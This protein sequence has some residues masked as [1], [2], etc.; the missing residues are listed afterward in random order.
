MLER[1]CETCGTAFLADVADCPSA[2]VRARADVRQETHTGGGSAT[3][4][5]T[6]A[7]WRRRRVPPARYAR[8]AAPCLRRASEPRCT[9]QTN[10]GS[11]LMPGVSAQICNGRQPTLCLKRCQISVPRMDERHC[12]KCGKAFLP[13]QGSGGRPQRFC[14]R[15]CHVRA[16]NS[17]RQMQ[18]A[19]KSRARRE[20]ASIVA[21]AWAALAPSPGNDYC[22]TCPGCGAVFAP[23]RSDVRYCSSECRLRAYDER[24][25]ANPQAGPDPRSLPR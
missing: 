14:S 20:A 4:N 23:S 11:A 19:A 24:R 5:G 16:S 6:P 25:R 7:G 21:Q 18:A 22:T 12:K 8:S 2:S 17:R 10:A 3:P 1:H 9:A 13:R 15:S